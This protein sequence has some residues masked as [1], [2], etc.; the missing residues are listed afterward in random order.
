[1]SSQTG[2]TLER[3]SPGF[4]V[5]MGSFL[6]SERGAKRLRRDHKVSMLSKSEGRSEGDLASGY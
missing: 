1:M 5:V 2:L 6:D 4:P 3:G